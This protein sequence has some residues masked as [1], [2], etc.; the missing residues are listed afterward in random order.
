MAEMKSTRSNSS[1]RAPHHQISDHHHPMHVETLQMYDEE[2]EDLTNLIY[3]KLNEAP[4]SVRDEIASGTGSIKQAVEHMIMTGFQQVP[5]MQVQGPSSLRGCDSHSTVMH[6]D[7]DLTSNYNWDYLLDWGPQ[8][9]PLAHVFSEIAR[10]KD[11]NMS[12]SGQSAASSIR[13]RNSLHHTIKH[14]PPP[15]ITN[16]APRLMAPV[17]SSR[18]SNASGRYSNAAVAAAVSHQQYLLRSNLHYEQPHGFSTPSPMPPS[19]THNLLPNSLNQSPS[20][21][22]EPHLGMKKIAQ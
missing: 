20:P 18:S 22:L 4:A 7:E 16:V 14:I 19:F 3:A 1:R 21:N 8:Y 10:L 12:V 15:L 11:D 17:I 2:N 6:G 5:V 9:Q 13:S